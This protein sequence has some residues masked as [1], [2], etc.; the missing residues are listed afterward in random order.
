[1]FWFY[2]TGLVLVALAVFGAWFWTAWDNWQFDEAEAQRRQAEAARQLGVPVELTVDLPPSPYSAGASDGCGA[3]SGGGVKL[4]LVLI[5]PGMFDMGSLENGS[6]AWSPDSTEGPIH[7][8]RISRA[9]YMGKCEVTQEQWEKVMGERRGTYHTRPYDP[10]LPVECL[11]WDDCQAFLKKLSA[12][13]PDPIR[14]SSGVGAG[15]DQMRSVC[16]AEA[17]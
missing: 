9:F 14:S 11:A 7:R 16:R 6:C 8:V 3:A 2:V 12:L 10:R 15:R 13:I 17:Q 1:M 5:P 4:E